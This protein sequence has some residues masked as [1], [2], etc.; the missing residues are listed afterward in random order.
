[1]VFPQLKAYRGRGRRTSRGIGPVIRIGTS[2]TIQRAFSIP[3][4]TASMMRCGK[5]AFGRNIS[6]RRS[7]TRESAKR[8]MTSR[9]NIATRTKSSF[10]ERR[11]KRSSIPASCSRGSMRSCCYGFAPSPCQ[12]PQDRPLLERWL[13]IA[14]IETPKAVR[15]WITGAATRVGLHV[16]VDVEVRR[17]KTSISDVIENAH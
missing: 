9:T 16:G 15:C 5:R 7:G 4:A 13:D 17:R 8:K 10:S 2:P 11:S 6:R 1:M 12:G 3:S 14:T